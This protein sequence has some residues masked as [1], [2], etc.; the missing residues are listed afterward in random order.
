LAISAAMLLQ[1]I[2]NNVL[3][4]CWSLDRN[5]VLWHPTRKRNG[6]ILTTPKPAQGHLCY[7]FHLPAYYSCCHYRDGLHTL[8]IMI[9]LPGFKCCITTKV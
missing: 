4:V 6:S 9:M 7:K 8:S 1:N 5:F 2:A 3:S